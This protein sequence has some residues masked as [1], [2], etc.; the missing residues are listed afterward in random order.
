M[1]STRP[2]HSWLGKFNF[3]CC[4]SL[5][6]KP[7]SSVLPMPAIDP[8][9]WAGKYG[10]FSVNSLLLFEKWHTAYWVKHNRIIFMYDL[11]RSVLVILSLLHVNRKRKLNV[12]TKTKV[13]RILDKI[14]PFCPGTLMLNHSLSV[15][16][17]EWSVISMYSFSSWAQ[18]SQFWI[19]NYELKW[20]P[21][22][23]LSH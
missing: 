7:Q 3:L 21:F 15:R 12:K 13:K 6:L 17:C 18:R 19:M 8:K 2:Y 10:W 11:Q 9:N 5:S 23:G 4:F 22:S 16:D 14:L 20:W 1:P